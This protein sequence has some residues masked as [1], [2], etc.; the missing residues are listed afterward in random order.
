MSLTTLYNADATRSRIRAELASGEHDVV[1]Y[2]GHAF[3][4]DMQRADS[5]IVC[6]REE[7]LR[8]S[9]V[10]SLSSLPALMVFNACE[11]ARVRSGSKQARRQSRSDVREQIDRSTGLAES[12]L[13]GGLA[14]YVGTYWPVGD[15][16]AQLFGEAFYRRLCAG[17]SVGSALQAGRATVHA[18]DSVDWAN[19]VHYGSF[20]FRLKLDEPVDQA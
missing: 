10:A 14:N 13:R 4:D 6:A 1:H 17:E 20:D 3:F 2:A 16:P 11:A 9:D 7:V 19:Y 5:G 12:F 15:K 8:G 18:E